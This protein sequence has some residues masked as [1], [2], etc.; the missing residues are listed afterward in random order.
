MVNRKFPTSK[1]Y[2]PNQKFQTKGGFLAGEIQFAN[3]PVNSKKIVKIQFVHC[4]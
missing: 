3:P 2:L 4:L 1:S